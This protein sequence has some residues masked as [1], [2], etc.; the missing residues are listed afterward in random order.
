M[1]FL[2]DAQLPRRLADYL[3]A[4]GHDAVHTLDLPNANRTT[5]SAT[6]TCSRCS[7]RTSPRSKP[8]SRPAAMSSCP[9]GTSSCICV[10]KADIVAQGYDLSLNRYKEV[11]HEVVEH[12][13]PRDILNELAGIE[14]EIQRGMKE[15]GGLLANP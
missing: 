14:E 3:R 11:V 15:L 5:E 2:V 7:P 8:P 10:P 12:R 6:T 13:K 4:A 1:K 9:P